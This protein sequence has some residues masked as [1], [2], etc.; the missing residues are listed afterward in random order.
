MPALGDFWDRNIEISSR[1]VKNR[2]F[3][4]LDPPLTDNKFIA[5]DT[6][7]IGSTQPAN[8]AD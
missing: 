1:L 4:S 6:S 8:F 3:P 2:I 5:T 7:C